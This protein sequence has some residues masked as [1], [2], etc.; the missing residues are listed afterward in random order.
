[1]NYVQYW[2]LSEKPFEDLCNPKYFYESDDHR[3]ALDRL[4]YIVQDRNMGI[5]LLTGEIGSGKTITRKVFERSLSALQYS[6]ASFDSYGLGFNDVLFE[7]MQHITFKN[8]AFEMYNEKLEDKREDK[9]YL[10]TM[11]KKYIQHLNDAEHRHLVVIIDE[12]QQLDK[13]TLDNLKNLTNIRAD[14]FNYM[15][16]VL[17]GQPELRETIKD[18]EQLNQRVHLRFHLNN[19]DLRNTRKYINH[20]LRIAGCIREDIF[21]TVGIELLYKEV[22][23]VPREINRACKLALDYGAASNLTELG[24]DVIRTVIDDFRQH[25]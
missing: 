20:R 6:V 19:L 17:I 18:L 10:L 13:H 14:N 11:F 25:S 3:E 21:N 24:E 15:T 4:L 16:I 8:A 1:M 12:A 9:Y 2:K 23:G 5:G 22:N 7:I